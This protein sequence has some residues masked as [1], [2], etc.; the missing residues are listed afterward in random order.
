MHSL[1]TSHTHL[2]D[3]QACHLYA[4]CDGSAVA[5]CSEAVQHSS[6][7]GGCPSVEPY[8]DTMSR[9]GCGIH[10]P[11][12]LEERPLAPLFCSSLRCGVL[13]LHLLSKQW[14]PLAGS[15]TWKSE[16][17]IKF[18]FKVCCVRQQWPCAQLQARRPFCTN[19]YEDS[20]SLTYPGATPRDECPGHQ[21]EH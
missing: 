18:L 14:G 21:R 17:E 8:Q 6:V 11:F 4:S 19:R 10:G 3:R 13:S 7:L 5:S 16:T 20:F 2:H 9:A 12:S 1:G 15:C